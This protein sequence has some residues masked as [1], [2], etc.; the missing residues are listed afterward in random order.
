VFPLLALVVELVHPGL[1]T[2]LGHPGEGG[3]T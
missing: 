1:V 3:D 2:A